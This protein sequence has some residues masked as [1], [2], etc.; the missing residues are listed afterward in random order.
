MMTPPLIWLSS[1]SL[2]MIKPQSWTATTFS[3]RDQAGV[4]IHGDFGE[5]HPASVIGRESRLPLAMNDQR[6]DAELLAGGK[7]VSYRGRRPGRS[8]LQLLECLGANVINRRGDRGARGAAAAAR[9]G[10][11]ACPPL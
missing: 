11:S 4:S 7:P 5:L 9:P 1:V 6:V 10:G 8:G 3:H 2:S